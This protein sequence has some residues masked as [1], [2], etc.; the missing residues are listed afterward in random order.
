MD[1]TGFVRNC[2]D[3]A[4]PHEQY[5]CE[6]RVGGCPSSMDVYGV[7]V[8]AAKCIARKGHKNLQ[9]ET[10]SSNETLC[11][12]VSNCEYIPEGIALV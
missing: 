9:C 8:S 12:L 1:A 4:D 11:L 7:G 3:F 5:L 2:E 10:M 6:T